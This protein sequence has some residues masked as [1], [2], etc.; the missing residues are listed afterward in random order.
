MKRIH[1]IGVCGTAMGSLAGLELVCRA[2]CEAA[3]RCFTLQCLQSWRSGGLSDLKVRCKHLD[4][5][6]DLV[7]VGNVVHGITLSGEMHIGENYPISRWRKRLPS[8]MIRDTR[9]CCCWHPRKDH[10]DCAWGACLNGDGLNP[11]Y[12]VG[13][14]LVG[15]SESFRFVGWQ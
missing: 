7:I 5:E 13:G 9:H 15:Y 11:S 10:N 1:M 12:L 6:P 14:A 3:M 2:R 4:P 8:F